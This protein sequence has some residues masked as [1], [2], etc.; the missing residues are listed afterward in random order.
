[1]PR[2]DDGTPYGTAGNQ[3]PDYVDLVLAELTRIHRKY[4]AAGYDAPLP[5]DGIGVGA[6][7]GPHADKTDVYLADIGGNGIYGY[8]TTDDEDA[9][10]WN[11]HIGVHAYCVLDNDYRTGQ[12]PFHT[13]R[14]N[15]QVTAAH[16]YFHAI[17]FG[18]DIAEDGWF[19]EATA[20][21]AEDEL[22]DAV[23]DNVSYLARGPIGRPQQPLDSFRGL[24]HYGAWIFFRHLT[25]R[26]SAKQG[27]LPRLVREMWDLARGDG[28]N[29]YSLHA[30]NRALTRRDTTLRQQFVRFATKNRRARQAYAEGRANR[31]PFTKLAGRA[32]LTPRRPERTGRR[33]ARPPDQ[34]H[35][36]VPAGPEARQGPLPAAAARPAPRRT[37]RC[38]DLHRQAHR[39]RPGHPAGPARPEGQQGHRRQADPLHPRPRA[40]G[41]GHPRQRQPPLRLQ[42]RLRSRPHLPRPGARRQPAVRAPGDRQVRSSG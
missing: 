27:P 13:P 37:R 16:E 4:V 21:W 42:L 35:P 33:A 26:Y 11:K 12:F 41:R 8:C 7:D 6:P 25:E 9:G 24:Y 31:Y 1:M 30:I 18:Y 19:M 10:R 20:T 40:V 23:D 22:Y 15:L 38:G 2:G 3:V 5:D 17:Q 34:P 36:P 39:S 14:Q 32:V 28:Q 29:L